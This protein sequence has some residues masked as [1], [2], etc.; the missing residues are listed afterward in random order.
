MDALSTFF[1]D[2]WEQLKTAFDGGL[3]GI[4]ELILNWSLL[5]LFYKAF[6]EVLSYFNID[7]P[8]SFSGFGGMLVD[9]L[10]SGITVR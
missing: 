10:V 4:A 3:L 5:G 6:A 2:L 1:S 7:L 8:K 9:D